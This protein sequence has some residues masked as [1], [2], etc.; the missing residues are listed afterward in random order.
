MNDA[1]KTFT[2][3]LNS[4]DYSRKVNFLL[5]RR[6]YAAAR[7]QLDAWLAHDPNDVYALTATALYY[8][9][10]E[11]FE[12]AERQARAA[13]RTK[14][15]SWEAMLQLCTALA[16][17]R[18]E[19]ALRVNSAALALVPQHAQVW[20]LRSFLFTV[21]R[22]H[23]EALTAVRRGLELEPDHPKLLHI[24]CQSLYHTG[25][26][27]A[28]QE[29]LQAALE[30]HPEEV[31]LLNFY[32]NLHVNKGNRREALAGLRASLRLDP[33]QTDTQRLYKQ[34]NDVEKLEQSYP[35]RLLSLRANGPEE[36]AVYI[37]A[38]VL[39]AIAL[40]IFLF[41]PP[42][43]DGFITSLFWQPIA[44]WLVFRS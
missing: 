12:Q 20:V 11:K 2:S 41:T 14:A 7:E 29:A 33:N 37:A 18:P 17:N 44:C 36:W 30:Q 5:A 27:Q 9:H 39:L 22:R 35:I 21:L 24:H 16:A 19:E 32:S 15:D 42:T 40:Q 34:V 10:Q 43:F 28:A 13:L 4:L 23:T 8:N 26:R 38:Q 6:Q 31:G 25:Q 1:T 3:L